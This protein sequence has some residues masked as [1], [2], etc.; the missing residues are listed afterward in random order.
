MSRSLPENTVDAWTAI[1]LAFDHAP[2][3]WLPTTNQGATRTGS[4]PGDISAICGRRLVLIENK[5]IEAQASIDFGPKGLEQCDYLIAV[6][7][8]GIAS[9][10]SQTAV[11]AM[12]W[13]LYGLPLMR[14]A[15]FGSNWQAFP[16]HQHLVCPHT[17]RCWGTGLRLTLDD[18]ETET[19]CGACAAHR[20]QG[21]VY[22][23]GPPFALPLTLDWLR[24]AVRLELLGLP[25]ETSVD[26]LFDQLRGLVREARGRFDQQDQVANDYPEPPDFFNGDNV[27]ELLQELAAMAAAWPGHVTLAVM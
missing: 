11:P 13:V 19:H 24:T 26:P 5:G 2:W 23:S 27:F 10:G 15:T 20:R 16:A 21:C 25:L 22:L 7:E 18:L 14:G 8:A 3:I 12:G 6:E 4:H 1:Q 17:V 9:S